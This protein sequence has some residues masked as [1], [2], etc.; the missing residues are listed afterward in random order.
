[1]VRHWSVQPLPVAKES[2]MVRHWSEQPL[3]V[4]KESTM[5]RLLGGV[6]H[7]V[8]IILPRPSG[9]HVPAPSC[10]QC[11]LNT[12]SHRQSR[13]HAHTQSKHTRAPG[14]GKPGLENRPVFWLGYLASLG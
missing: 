3:P 13:C 12:Q 5:V 6:D 8:E 10:C 1:M 11:P 9:C 7:S 4:A 2:T 14:F